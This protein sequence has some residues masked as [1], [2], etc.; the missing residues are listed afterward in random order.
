MGLPSLIRP[1]GSRPPAARS[2]VAELHEIARTRAHNTNALWEAVGRVN[3][4]DLS[5]S[6]N[7]IAEKLPLVVEA[8]YA[9]IRLSDEEGMLHLVAASGCAAS[10]I[11]IRAIEPVE[12]RVATRLTDSNA[13]AHH[14]QAQGFRWLDIRWLGGCEDPMGSILLASRTERRP[15][16]V[17][18]S[19]LDAI[20][21]TLTETLTTIQ[22]RGLH[23]RAC[24]MRLARS[25]Q[26]EGVAED[27]QGAVA[28]LRRKERVVL[29]LYADGMTTQQVADFLVISEHT[30]RTHVKTALRTLSVHSRKDAIELV[31]AT[32]VGLF[33]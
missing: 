1:V 21:E 5:A 33:L 22:K 23:A 29:G 17:Q 31:R 20:T 28:T 27:S 18:L 30:V 8:D 2:L 9:S 3:K 7:A 10:E 32:E 15:E 24:A 19:T 6:L 13:L 11:R 25:V 4:A 16:P 14:G 26:P 12:V